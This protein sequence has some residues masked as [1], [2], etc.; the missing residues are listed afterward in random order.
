MDTGQT[1]GVTDG[2]SNRRTKCGI[3]RFASVLHP[4]DKK[5]CLNSSRHSWYSAGDYYNTAGPRH[6]LKSLL[7]TKKISRVSV[8]SLQTLSYWLNRAKFVLT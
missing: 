1:D 3:P 4:R 7:Y 5:A 8:Y 6:R 2:W